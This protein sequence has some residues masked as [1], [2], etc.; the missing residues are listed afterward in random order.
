MK[1]AIVIKPELLAEAKIIAPDLYAY[2]CNSP[3]SIIEFADYGMPDCQMLM[4]KKILQLFEIL[5]KKNG[6]EQ[7]HLMECFQYGWLCGYSD[8]FEKYGGKITDANRH[9]KKEFFFNCA[10]HYPFYEIN[11][12]LDPKNYVMRGDLMYNKLTYS[13][14]QCLEAW[15]FM[16]KCPEDFNDFFVGLKPKKNTLEEYAESKYPGITKSAHE[17]VETYKESLHLDELSPDQQILK[18]RHEK[19]I[20]EKELEATL[21]NLGLSGFNFK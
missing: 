5:S 1:N 3:V 12:L 4:P 19:Q 2:Y 13:E 15:R 11:S 16:F 8:L 14:A 20:A 17:K 6:N 21:K 18:L 10:L 9:K 7:P